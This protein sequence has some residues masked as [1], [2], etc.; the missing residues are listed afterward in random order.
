[1]H[2]QITTPRRVILRDLLLFQVKLILDGLK[3]LLL[4]QLSVFAALADLFL[5]GSR[6]G[7]IFY[8]FMR[9]CE[10][11]DL[12]LNLYS[13]ASLAQRT[14]GG[15]IEERPRGVDSLLSTIEFLVA[16]LFAWIRPSRQKSRRPGDSAPGRNVSP[17]PAEPVAAEPLGGGQVVGS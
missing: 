4:V 3:D 14:P 12:W 8:G 16:G 15:L 2:N 9:S 10:R 13:A 17:L 7:W 6:R 5:G 1:V 11:F